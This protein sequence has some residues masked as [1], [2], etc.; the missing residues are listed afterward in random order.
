MKL[1]SSID[2]GAYKDALLAQI[3]ATATTLRASLVTFGAPYAAKLA[4][5][6]AFLA[7]ATNGVPLPYL[8]AEATARGVSVSEVATSVVEADAK[9]A[10]ALAKIEAHRVVAK[11]AV[12]A[13]L[14]HRA[15]KGAA[16]RAF[17]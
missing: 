2:L 5:A 11:M 12:K 4:E 14:N 3:D 16:D 13:A 17:A 8:T 7:G 10:E 6:K 15:A 1:S 9:S